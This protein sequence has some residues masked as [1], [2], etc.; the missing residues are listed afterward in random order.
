MRFYILFLCLLVH[1]AFSPASTDDVE[2]DRNIDERIKK[3]NRISP[4][5]L[6]AAVNT[7]DKQVQDL[8]E[9]SKDGNRYS[10]SYVKK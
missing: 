1:S 5:Q 3:F 4:R 8:I 2:N 6:G 7:D 10:Y 9:V